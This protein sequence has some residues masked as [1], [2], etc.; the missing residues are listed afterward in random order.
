M[1]YY[2][3]LVYDAA[4][5]FERREPRFFIANKKPLPQGN[6]LLRSNKNK[7]KYRL[8]YFKLLPKRN[9]GKEI[10]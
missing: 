10:Y 9:L 5:E 8:E 7:F 1:D 2:L 6:K 3:K 4:R